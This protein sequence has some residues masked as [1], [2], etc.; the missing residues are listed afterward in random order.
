MD[1]KE[2]LQSSTQFHTLPILQRINRH[3][4]I[5]GILEH[6]KIPIAFPS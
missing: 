5:G 4:L 3:L 6:S 1:K 2:E